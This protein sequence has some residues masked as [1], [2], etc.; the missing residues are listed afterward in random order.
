MVGH[1]ALEPGILVLELPQAAELGHAEMPVLLLPENERR[2][3]DAELATDVADGRP[4]LGLAQAS[5]S[6]EN[7]DRFIV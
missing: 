4:A 7:L 1:D 5:C 6:S 3:T 2:L